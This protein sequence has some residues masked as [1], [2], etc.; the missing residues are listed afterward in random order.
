MINIT[1]AGLIGAITGTVVAGIVYHL[2]IDA[3]ERWLR[4]RWQNA[5]ESGGL[6]AEMPLVRRALLTADLLLLAAAGYW[7][8]NRIAG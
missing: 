3:F 1:L 5:S 7:L 2:L 4:S 6:E 8:G